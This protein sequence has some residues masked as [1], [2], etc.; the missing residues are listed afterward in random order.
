VAELPLLS[1]NQGGVSR[2]AAELERA[3]RGY[4][5][6]RAQV[7]LEVRTAAARLEQARAALG[8]WSGEIV[9]ELEIEQRQAERAYEAGE[10]ALISVLDVGRRLVQ[11]R[12]HVA[13]A[14]IE[15][16]RAVIG[17]E[18]SAGRACTS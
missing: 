3:S 8:I 2:A 9:P 16:Q 18:R 5:A 13:D 1:R 12:M 10:V 17:V 14:R 4:L 11:A 7:A 6:V 15:L